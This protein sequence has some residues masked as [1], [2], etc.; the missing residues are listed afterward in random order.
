MLFTDE[1]FNKFKEKSLKV[2]SLHPGLILT[3]LGRHVNG[4]MICFFALFVCFLRSIPRGA[5]TTLF[6][7]VSNKADKFNGE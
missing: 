4:C 7:A 6:A 2:F 5:T 3:D 1:L